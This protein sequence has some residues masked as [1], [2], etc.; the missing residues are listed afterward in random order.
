MN[1]EPVNLDF[2]GGL[3]LPI[4]PSQHWEK[5]FQE[6][7]KERQESV[8][9]EMH[10]LV[11]LHDMDL[12]QDAK[13]RFW[14][15]FSEPAAITERKKALH[16]LTFVNYEK[17]RDFLNNANWEHESREQD[18]AAGNTDSL[19]MGW[20]DLASIG[21]QFAA[22]VHARDYKAFERMAKILKEGKTP[23]SDTPKGGEHSDAGHMIRQFIR[24][25]LESRSLPTK[26]E[27]RG[28]CGMA[29]DMKRA[30]DLMKTLGLSGLPQAS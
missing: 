6:S 5:L 8:I 18:L 19:K 3:V 27:L 23:V 26:K 30:S 21:M 4:V 12:P 28:A 29:K 14:Q 11:V 2:G 20:N 24:L 25:H 17:E 13:D 9:D 15:A 16:G 1:D 22:M 7:D 10:W